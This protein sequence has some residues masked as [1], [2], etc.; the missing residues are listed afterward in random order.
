M[1]EAIDP[2]LLEFLDADSYDQQ[3]LILS[4]LQGRITDR[5]IDT[6]A[7]SLELEIGEGEVDKRCDEL[8]HCLL[9]KQRFEGDR[10]R[11]RR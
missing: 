10:E 6:M 11:L 3:L 5:M 4:Q 1:N 7:A 2:Q 9:T 8:R